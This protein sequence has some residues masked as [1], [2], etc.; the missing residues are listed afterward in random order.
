MSLLIDVIVIAAFAICFISGFKKGFIKSVMGIVI[1]IAA[2]FGSVKLAPAVASDLNDKYINKAVTNI[3]EDSVESLLSEDVDIDSLVRDM[4]TAFKKVLDRFGVEPEEISFLFENID[5]SE[6][7]SEKVGI[8]AE[9]IAS[10]I[11]SALSKAA[12]FLLVFAV[13]YAVLL[14]AAWVLCAI[15]KL[16]MLNAANKL[17]GAVFGAASGLLLAWGLSVAICELMPHLAVLYE[18]SVPE[19]VIENSIVVKFLGS[20]DPMNLIK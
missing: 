7:D 17:L 6:P 14:L 3:A 12:A 11:S 19:T 9:R 20:I 10:P 8:I 13:L 1:V 15:V 4:P 16:P 18:E 5:P 2:I